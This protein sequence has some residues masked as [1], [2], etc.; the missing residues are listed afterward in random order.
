MPTVGVKRDELFA[1]IG[2]TFTDEE[3][4]HLC[5]EFGIELDDVTSERQ[6]KQKEQGVNA[7]IGADDTIIYKID[8]PA[9]RYD[10]LCVEGI[11]R[12]LRVFMK[13]ELPPVFQVVPAKNHEVHRLTVKH[14]NGLE[15]IRPYAVSCVLRGVT[16]TQARY[17][18]FIDLQ[19][20]LHQNICRRRTLVAIG[21]HD[22]D[23]IEGPFTY[24]AQAPSDISFVPLSQSRVFNAKELLDHYRTSPDSKHLKPYTDIIYDFPA[25]PVIYDKNRTVLSLPPIINS[26][27]SKIKLSTRNVFIE[28]TATDITKA[29]IVLN[30]VIAMF[31]QYCDAPFTVE[32]VEVMY[33]RDGHRE[34]TPDLSNRQVVT[35]VDDIHSMLFGKRPV[36]DLDVQRICDLCVKMQLCATYLPDVHSIEVQVPP[37]RSDILHAVD[38]MEDVGIAYG[39][40][41]IPVTFPPTLTVGGGQPLNKLGD[42]LRDEISRAGYIELLT[43]GLCSHDENFKFL[44]RHDNSTSAVVLSNPATIEFEVVRTTMIPGVLK[45]VQNNKG[46]SFKDGLKLF[47]I[48]DVVVLN[49]AS[50]VGASNIR[51]LCALY[52]GQTDGFEV[53]HGLVDRVM[54]LIGVQCVL[55]P[56][57]ATENYYSIIPSSNP[58]FFEG[59]CADIVWHRDG[60]KIKLGTFGVLHPEVLNNYELLYP[61][62]V[63]EMDIEPLV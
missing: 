16:F 60:G 52:T 38:V 51:R 20:K 54:Q 27:H 55:D 32:P 46:M 33:E 50:D 39:F 40:D 10:L 12:A 45:T 30:T 44:N 17:D 34:V 21:T 53:I 61:A 8:V 56:E 42:H 4:D 43:H 63:V 28:C 7:A 15:T 25:Y 23:T 62:S 59:R 24:E 57:H 35:K 22:L 31:S 3:F 5:F 41:N 48:S 26:E 14:G 1:A 19:D 36:I 18:S 58:T 29:N 6:I 49:P 9:N 13:K 11:A 47:E 2:Q 37:T